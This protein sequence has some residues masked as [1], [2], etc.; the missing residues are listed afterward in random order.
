MFSFKPQHT[1][2]HFGGLEGAGIPERAGSVLEGPGTLRP[3][4][5]PRAVSPPLPRGYTAG[6]APPRARTA[7]SLPLMMGW[8]GDPAAGESRLLSAGGGAAALP[9]P[10]DAGPAPL[11]ALGGPRAAQPG[12]P[13]PRP[14][15]RPFRQ[16]FRRARCRAVSS[17][18]RAGRGGGTAPKEPRALPNL[19]GWGR[20]LWGGRDAHGSGE[21]LEG[22]ARGGLE[23]AAGV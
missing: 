21:G 2:P 12:P 7:P 8:I 5:G 6:W 10:G 19:R 16:R 20:L 22:M 4:P 17:S 3:L 18:R 15:L 23:G 9:R 1:P 14:G 11:M 13:R